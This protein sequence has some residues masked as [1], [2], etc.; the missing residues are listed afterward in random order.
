MY[1]FD[2]FNLKEDGD[3]PL[4]QRNVHFVFLLN[5][6]VQNTCKL[7]FM[8]FLRHRGALCVLF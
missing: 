4:I 2:F 8:Y 7:E 3:T 6:D 1:G 5:L